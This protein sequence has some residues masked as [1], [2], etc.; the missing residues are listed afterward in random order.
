MRLLLAM[1]SL[2]VLGAEGNALRS[3]PGGTPCIAEPG[4]EAPSRN[5]YCIDL[6]AVPDLDGATGTFELNRVPS[7]FGV[8]V[9]RD[10]NQV[11]A[12]VLR[13]TGLPAP[14]RFSPGPGSG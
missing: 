12:P 4:T 10:G 2:V 11:Y 14:E 1:L 3:E 7:P 5:L 6:Q 13:I 8:N 9:T